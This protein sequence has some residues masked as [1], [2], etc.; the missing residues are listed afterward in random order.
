MNLNYELDI[1]Y[2]NSIYVVISISNYSKT[3]ITFQEIDNTSSS[4]ILSNSVYNQH[5]YEYQNGVSLRQQFFLHTKPFSTFNVYCL[6]Y[7]FFFKFNINI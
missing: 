6:N 3:N 1:I 2:I 7:F 4:S 5:Y